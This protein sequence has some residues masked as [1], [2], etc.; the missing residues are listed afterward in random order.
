MRHARQRAA[1]PGPA[2]CCGPRCRRTG[3]LV[4]VVPETEE[5][6]VDLAALRGM[7]QPGGSAGRAPVLVSISHVPT[8]SGKRL[9]DQGSAQC[10]FMA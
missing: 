3:V 1:K 5:G 10:P 2:S 8:S 6:D 9:G 7:L 4:E